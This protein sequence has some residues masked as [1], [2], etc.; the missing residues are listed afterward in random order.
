MMFCLLAARVPLAQ[1]S[2]MR[3]AEGHGMGWRTFGEV[4][5]VFV[6]VFATAWLLCVLLTSG[7]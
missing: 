5:M 7:R 6:A 4:L 1:S 3:G 2:H